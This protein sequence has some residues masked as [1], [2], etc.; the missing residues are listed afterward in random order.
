L[1]AREVQWTPNI[2]STLELA[3]LV[4]MVENKEITGTAGKTLLKHL[5]DIPQIDR[6]SVSSL[7]DTL[8]LR[9]SVMDIEKLCRQAI[10]QLPKEAESVRKGNQ[11]VLMRLVGQVMKISGGTADA[12]KARSTL[13]DLLK[14]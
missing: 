11:R 2:V 1:A 5:I 7:V 9:S 10:E 13:M 4:G 3:Q 6:P 12:Q 14:E 8:G